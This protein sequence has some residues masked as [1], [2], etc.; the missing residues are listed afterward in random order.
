M[1]DGKGGPSL[2]EKLSSMSEAGAEERCSFP[3]AVDLVF[4]FWKEEKTGETEGKTASGE[5]GKRGKKEKKG[6]GGD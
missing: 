3:F 6:I 4:A 2:L 5:G 1:N